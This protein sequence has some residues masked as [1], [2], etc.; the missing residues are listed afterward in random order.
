[1]GYSLLGESCFREFP[2]SFSTRKH[3]N[4]V[5]RL[6]TRS[7]THNIKNVA[8]HP[9]Y[10]CA[11]KICEDIWFLYAYT[12]FVYICM[13]HMH[14]MFLFD[15]GSIRMYFEPVVSGDLMRLREP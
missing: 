6:G 1:M 5:G 15:S 8:K 11:I 3:N 2:F 4:S 12:T 10:A 7:V 9:V 13:P 14:C